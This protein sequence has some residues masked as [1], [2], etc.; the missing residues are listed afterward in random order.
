MEGYFLLVME[1][2]C[3]WCGKRF[4]SKQTESI[5][6]GFRRFIIYLPLEVILLYSLNAILPAPSFQ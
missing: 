6:D 1:K 4:S 2:F 3:V 5:L